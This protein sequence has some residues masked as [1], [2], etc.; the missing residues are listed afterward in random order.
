MDATLSFLTVSQSNF[1]YILNT[2]F[3]VLIIHISNCIR[4]KI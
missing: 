1:P 2:G 3:I 4:V